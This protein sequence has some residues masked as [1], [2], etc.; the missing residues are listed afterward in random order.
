M[1]RAAEPV[2]LP[3]PRGIVLREGECAC[4]ADLVGRIDPAWARRVKADGRGGQVALVI[5]PGLSLTLRL[6]TAAVARHQG[7]RLDV[8]PEAIAIAGHD[9]GGLFYG[10]MTLRQLARAGRDAGRLPCIAIED[11]P[12]LAVRGAMLDV[13]RDRVP[14]MERLLETIDRLAEFKINQIQLYME[15]AFAYERHEI[16]WRDASPF[17]AQEIRTIDAFCRARFIELVPNQN[18]FGHM[19][20]WLRHDP[21]NAL[22][23]LP[24]KAREQFAGSRSLCPIDERVFPFLDGLYGELLPNFSSRQFNAG[25]DETFD[26]G[27]GRSREACAARGPGRV[28]LDYLK[29][30]YELVCKHGHRMLFWADIILHYPEL[31]GELPRDWLT[32]LVWGYEADHPFDEQCRRLRQSSIPFYVCPGTSSWNALTGRTANM[33]ANMTA[34]ARAAAGGAAGLLVTDWGDNG[35][36]QHP[37]LAW[38]GFALG[39]ALAWSLQANENLDLA[40]ALD[41]H[42]FEPRDGGIGAALLDLGE[43]CL[44]SGV[45]TPNATIFAQLLLFPDRPL[46]DERWAGLSAER[47]LAATAHIQHALA[48][49]PPAAL[50]PPAAA[51]A[52][53][54]IQHNAALAFHACRQGLTRLAAGGEGRVGDIDAARRAR[55]ADALEPL[56]AE[57]R[58]LWL[59]DSRP[60]GLADSAGRLEKL[61]SR[62]RVA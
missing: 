14:T 52:I 28:Y 25:L 47:L 22:A 51:L 50:Q 27:Q 6:D 23:E 61:V 24:E 45:Q 1:N 8:A 32:A 4:P 44:E 57:H 12:D 2:L 30:V 41:A 40:G 5:G 42:L 59:A 53:R 62:Y 55:L 15:H 46:A 19:E 17:T 36:W 58:R 39:A 29:K 20:R 37:P 11:W 9:S 33:R 49:L 56:V 38:P 16:V 3:R 31:I 7:Y 35:H 21:Y 13:S 26:L 18:S 43:A 60:G 34:A 10:L 48:G 54:Q